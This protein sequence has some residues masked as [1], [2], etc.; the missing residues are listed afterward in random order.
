[1][2]LGRVHFRLAH[3]DRRAALARFDAASCYAGLC[4]LAASLRDH[5]WM[6]VSGLVEPLRCGRFTRA[7]SDIDIALPLPDLEAAARSV[8]R[9][10]YALT[11]RVLRTHVSRAFDLEL[12]LRIAPASLRKP[13]RHLRL[14]RL[15]AGGDLDER[16]FPPYIDVFPYVVADQHLHI[17][18]SGQRLAMR[19]PLAAEVSL[20]GGATVPVEDPYYLEALRTARRQAQATTS[21]HA[22]GRGTAAQ[23][24]R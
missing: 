24:K 14:W 20:P 2:H 22:P 16:A 21:P 23:R 11:V 9:S 18:D 1:M 13:R 3:R 17:L 19:C 7:H 4:D 6:V 5:P 12:H 10:G 8:V 15:T